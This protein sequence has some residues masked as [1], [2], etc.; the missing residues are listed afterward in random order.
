VAGMKDERS[1][2]LME[3]AQRVIPGGVNSPVRAF[4]AVGGRPLVIQRGHGSKVVDADGNVYIDYVMAYGPLIL[5]HA[6]PKVVEAMEKAARDGTGFGATTEREVLLAEK[7]VQAVPGV[8]KVRL[9]NSGTEATMSA[10]RLARA[11][12]GRR[13]AVKFA[14][15]YHGH[16]DALLAQS[17]SGLSTLGIPSTP[18]VVPETARDTL[19]LPYNDLQAVEQAFSQYGDEIACVIVEPVAANMGVVPPAPG[20]LQGLREVTRRYGSLLI[21][22]EVI[23]G[24]RLGLAGAQGYYGVVP[25]LTCMGKVIGGGMPVGAYG[26]R[27]EL[28]DMV[29]PEGPVYQA[30]TLAG[31]PV[32]VA[33]GLATLEVLEE[34]GES[35]Y[36]QL[37]QKAEQLNREIRRAAREAGVELTV[38]Q[39]ESLSSWFFQPGPVTDYASVL[40][41]DTG[42]FAV[43]F[44]AMLERGIYLAP[45]QFEAVFIS[46]AHSREDLER[47]AEAARQALREVA[48]HLDAAQG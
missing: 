41:S 36:G 11:A 42:A 22:D 8:E 3:R 44:R 9:V 33:C 27:A 14:G 28:L 4:K 13:R 35:L 45:S 16:V 1:Q 21:F 5:G 12:T 2:Q 38:T 26:G 23:T 48:R 18:G 19:V 32:A 30:G 43:F 6:H 25:D 37:R 29:A 46:A 15:C 39:V 7:I 10:L 34:G 24:F 40:N 17:G 31:N 47:T 20:F